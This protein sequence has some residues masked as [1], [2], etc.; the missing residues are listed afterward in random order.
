MTVTENGIVDKFVEICNKHDV[1]TSR[2]IVEI[3]ETISGACDESLSDILKN[4]SD[5][6]FGISLDDFGSGYSNL[7]ALISSDFDELKIDML[8][9]ANMHKDKKSKSLTKVA[10][11]I[12]EEIDGLSSVAEGIETIE[13]FELLKDLNCDRG[14]GYYFD[15]PMPIADFEKKYIKY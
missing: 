6:G 7:T 12:C 2:I 8:L 15:K 5:A 3:T 13:Q 4:F 1:L 9:V 11:N 14:Q 10:L